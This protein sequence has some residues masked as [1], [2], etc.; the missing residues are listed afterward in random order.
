MVL[1]GVLKLFE[2][3]LL[4]LLHLSVCKYQPNQWNWFWWNSLW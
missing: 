4:V 3:Y 2:M 1:L